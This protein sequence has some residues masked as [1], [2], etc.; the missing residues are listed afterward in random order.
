MQIVSL[1]ASAT[2]I[3]CALGLR[4]N[5]VGISHECDYPRDILGLPVLSE[6]KIDP[7]RESA[8]I[9]R[10]V[11]DLV[12]DGLSVYRIK[13]D[14]LQRLKPDLIVTQDQCE[15]C[16]VSLKDV[17]EALCT[18]TLNQTQLCTLRPNTLDDIL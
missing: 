14:V 5:L 1:I 17:E 6:P 9:D 10:S 18:L 3:L 12:Q 15:V 7:H 4:Q 13:T 8:A 16:A 2:A 11:R